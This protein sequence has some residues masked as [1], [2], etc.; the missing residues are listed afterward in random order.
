MS[1][2]D[3]CSLLQVM[4]TEAAKLIRAD[5]CTVLIHDDEFDEL[6]S[7]EV[8]EETEYDEREAVE[9]RRPAHIGIAG[10]VLRSRAPMLVTDVGNSEDFDEELD[11]KEDRPAH[12]L[13]CVPMGR[14]RRSQEDHDVHDDEDAPLGVI[15][16]VSCDRSQAPTASKLNGEIHREGGTRTHVFEQADLQLLVDF[17]VI[18]TAAVN[19]AKMYQDL[20]RQNM[21]FDRMTEAMPHYILMLSAEGMLTGHNNSLL[22]LLGGRRAADNGT[23]ST[24]G[25][26]STT[27]A[28]DGAEY[29]ASATPLGPFR[30]TEE[31]ARHLQSAHFTEWIDPS[32]SQFLRH[33][34]HVMLTREPV[35][36]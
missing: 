6:W 18:A 1:E 24:D 2:L 16:V 11:Q 8:Q 20:M 5:Y 13:L 23:I 7:V 33:I 15:M 28:T 4:E 29:C 27:V 21:A 31:H 19:N 22:D 32:N 12:T 36:L 3:L 17:G 30:S 25:T 35:S 14:A 10:R 26:I 9:V 34:L